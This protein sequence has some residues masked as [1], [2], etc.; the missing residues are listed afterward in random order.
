MNSRF[1]ENCSDVLAVG[2][3]GYVRYSCSVF[4]SHT[5]ELGDWYYIYTFY[6]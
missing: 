4:Y 6:G 2:A 1:S 3:Y 5:D